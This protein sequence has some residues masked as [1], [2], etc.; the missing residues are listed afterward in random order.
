MHWVLFEFIFK[1]F[2]LYH[3]FIGFRLVFAYIFNCSRLLGEP[4]TT[5]PSS[6]WC[7]FFRW[8]CAWMW[9]WTSSLCGSI[10]A[11]QD[12]VRVTRC[13]LFVVLFLCRMCQCGLHAT[14]WSH[15]GSLMRLLAAEPRSIAG[16]LFPCQCLCG[17]ILVTPCSIVR[18]WRVSRAAPMPFY[19][20]SARSLFVSAV[21]PFSSFILWVDV[22]GLGSSDW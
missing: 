10:Y 7:R 11:V 22:V 20:P 4:L 19:G 2:S 12:Q 13:T 9:P 3:S 8:G 5:G 15:I 14:L 18:D 16:L 6:Q 21:F 1:P 17:T